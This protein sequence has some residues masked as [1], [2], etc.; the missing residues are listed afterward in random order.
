[1][2]VNL[3]T[4]KVIILYQNWYNAKSGDMR[5]KNLLKKSNIEVIDLFRRN[6]F[7]SKTIKQ[8][9]GLLGKP[10]PKVHASI[11]ELEESNLITIDKVGKSSL[12]KL[13]LSQGS[14]SILSFLDEQEAFSKNIPNIGKILEF[15]EFLDDILLVTG[16]YAKGKDTKNSDIDLVLITRDDA[17][18]KQKLLENVTSLFKP[19]VHPVVI[20][21][22]DFAGM[23]TGK[24][25][26]YGKEIFNNRLIFRNA[27]RYYEIVKEAIENGFRG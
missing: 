24:E 4:K 2:T 5:Q 6:I 13:N 3:Y 11:K 12:C 14:I 7:L 25:D 20:T 1:V 16:S 27:K 23:L 21:Y 10:Y 26:S 22:K 17:F 8:L 15:K 18:K 9:S 19:A